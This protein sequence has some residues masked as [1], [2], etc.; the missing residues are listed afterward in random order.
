MYLI[1]LKINSF[2]MFSNS[3][4]LNVILNLAKVLEIKDVKNFLLPK[5]IKK[6]TVIRS[7]HIDKKSR[8]QL[9]I[10][11]FKR[12]L[13]LKIENQNI[14]LLFLEILKNLRFYGVE[15]ELNIRF[16]SYLKRK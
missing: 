9:E 16:F 6:I 2:D 14:A 5:K 1:K 4:T 12:L 7:P 10:K 11:R 15:I 3:V 8:E 13:I